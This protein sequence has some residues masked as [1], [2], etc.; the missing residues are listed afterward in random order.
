M[1]Q[2][3]EFYGTVLCPQAHT[4]LETSQARDTDKLSNKRG[5]TEKEN[6]KVVGA[7]KALREKTR[8]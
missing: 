7:Y 5:I 2:T 8:K 4:V 1:Q 6:K 3:Y